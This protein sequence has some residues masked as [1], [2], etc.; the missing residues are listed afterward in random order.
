M[1]EIESV[2]GVLL[3]I[4]TDILSAPVGR[5]YADAFRDVLVVCL[6]TSTFPTAG[7][8][9]ASA[10]VRGGRMAGATA[11]S[12]AAAAAS[13]KWMSRKAAEDVAVVA[14]KIREI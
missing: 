7:W 14:P 9:A 2:R 1:L 10:C 13:W 4:A 6:A 12:A 3:S 11:A 8:S 5:R